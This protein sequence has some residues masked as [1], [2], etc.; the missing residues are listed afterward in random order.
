VVGAY[1]LRGRL[2]SI[3][4]GRVTLPPALTD[5]V[6]SVETIAR[7]ELPPGDFELR[8]AVAVDGSGR[9]GSVFSRV[10]VP[11]F[12]AVPLALSNL[13]IVAGPSTV[14]IPRDAMADLLPVVPSGVRVFPAG[15]D[16]TAFMRLYQGI[17]RSEAIE[18]VLVT[19]SVVDR[20]G[21]VRVRQSLELKPAEFASNRAA[22]CRFVLPVRRLTAGE[23]LFTVEAQRG[24]RVAG[25]AIRFSVR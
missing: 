23:Y 13:A 14:T 25:R 19:A 12:A 21:Q 9:T 2:A 24:E 7:L 15:S 8:A 4:E 11:P 22:D 5:G 16:V 17:G 20:A 3:V 6:E 10:T 1:D 18:S